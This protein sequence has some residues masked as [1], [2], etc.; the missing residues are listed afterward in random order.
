MI[1]LSLYR[2]GP[3]PW[4]RPLP[5]LHIVY[6]KCEK[7][8]TNCFLSEQTDRTGQGGEN[9]AHRG[10]N[11][12]EQHARQVYRYLHSLTVDGDMAEG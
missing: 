7:S 8:V 5:F 12:Y 3:F 6:N 4:E 2:Q 9:V 1:F 11:L 10:A